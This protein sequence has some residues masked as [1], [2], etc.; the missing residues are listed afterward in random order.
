MKKVIMIILDGLGISDNENGNVV[1]MANIPNLNRF[2]KEFPTSYLEASGEIVGLPKGIRGNSEVGHMTLGCGRTIIQPLT[3]INSKIKDKSFFENDTLLDVM[4]H[5]NE[6]NSTLH[7]V[8]L[9]SNSGI[10]SSLDH[11][12]AVLALAK[13]RKIKNVIFHFITD[14]RDEIPNGALNII[15]NFME[16]A[17]KLGIGIIGT[18]CGRYYAMDN[19]GNYDRIKKAYDAMVFNIGNNFADYN[20]CLELHYKN[21]IYDEYVNPSIIYKG[22]NINDNDGVIFVDFRSE[23]IKELISAFCDESFNMFNVKKFRNLKTAALYGTD[24]LIDYAYTNEPISGFFGQYLSELDFKQARISEETKYPYVTYFFDGANEF[25]DKNLYKILVPSSK[26]PKS[27]MKPEMSAGEITQAIINSIEDDFDFIL[28]NFANLDM[29]GHTG[30]IPAS[31]RA[32]EACDI[33]LGHILEKAQEN[34]YELVI[35]SDHGN[36]ENMK[37]SDGHIVTSHSDNKVPFIICNK[38]YKMEK[39]GS[40]KDVIPTI[41]DIFEISK[42]KEMTG[43]SL[44]IKD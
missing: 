24:N 43:K 41:V 6:N 12:Y 8:G 26:M 33:C 13:I 34:F 25:S 9:L 39:S 32:I 14:G 37:D 44:I 19:G 31:I 16:R 3:L 40:L 5:V 21:N 7:L 1:K 11:F 42:P 29:V 28:A 35:V 4:D 27:D 15:N 2:M 36:I 17:S 20:K 18:I 30:N 38:D 22:S 10:H 23:R